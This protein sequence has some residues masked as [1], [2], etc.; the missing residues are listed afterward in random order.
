[1]HVNISISNKIYVSNLPFD[2]EPLVREA[3]TVRR[4]ATLDQEA[5]EKCLMVKPGLQA[6]QQW[7]FPRGFNTAL[8]KGL[9]TYCH[10]HSVEDKRS[11]P[12]ADWK[13]TKSINLRAH[14]QD[15]IDAINWYREGVVVAPPAAG[16]TV[17]V[18]E[19]AR[20]SGTRALIIVD[21]NNLIDQWVKRCEEFL[22]ITPNII[23][24]GKLGD[25]KSSPITIGM[26][27]TLVNLYRGVSKIDYFGFVCLDECHHVS[28]NT[29]Q[30]VFEKFSASYRIGLSATPYRDDGLDLI[31]QLVIGPVIYKIDSEALLEQKYLMRPRIERIQTEFKHEFWSTHRVTREMICD[32]PRCPKN[33]TTHGHKNNYMAVAKALQEDG[34]RGNQIARKV[35]ENINECNLIVADRLEYL[36]ELREYCILQGFPPERTHMLTG[37][38]TPKE[39][40]EVTRLAAYGACAI[41]STIAKEALD[42]PR[43]DRLYLTWP[44]RKDH[45]LE[46][47]IGRITRTHPD[48]LEAVVYDFVDAGCPVLSNQS[49]SRFSYY[50]TKNYNIK[51]IN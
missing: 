19:A 47:Q 41:F 32:K 43:L 27:Q 36:R 50:R 30:D 14:Q 6:G 24:E 11:F 10:P 2:L 7:E 23:S 13:P 17:L 35:I 42:I 29:Y 33:G 12:V 46:Q 45:I 1:M 16:K 15:A 18:L 26:Q 22:G 9:Y 20:Q 51:E 40:A 49:W 4:P 21:K 28:A 34:I 39:R 31:S 8:V 44:I 38:E 37:K 3:L 25:I 48:K 5:Y